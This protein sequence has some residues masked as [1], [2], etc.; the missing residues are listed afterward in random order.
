[1]DEHLLQQQVQT[2]IRQFGLLEQEHTPCNVP[3]SPSQAHALQVF[4]TEGILTQSQLTSRL[5][6]EK[7]TV[8]RLVNILVEQGWVAR[9][10]NPENRREVILEITRSGQHL[11]EEV[12]AQALAKYQLL[13]EHLRPEKRAQILDSLATLNSILKEE[14]C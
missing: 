6:L 3:L 11:F 9:T 14:R 10:M 4:G 7:S 1:M 13:W 12:Q 5:H 8:S 2:F